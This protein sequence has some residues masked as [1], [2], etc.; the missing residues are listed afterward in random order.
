MKISSRKSYVRVDQQPIPIKDFIHFKA[1][2][3]NEIILNLDNAENLRNGEL[4]SGLYELGKRDAEGKYDWN[5][6][7]VTAKCIADLKKRMGYLNCNNCV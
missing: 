4:I 5:S 7:P 3:G 2:T 1:M 6:H